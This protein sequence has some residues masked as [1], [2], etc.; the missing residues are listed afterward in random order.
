MTD[1]ARLT[2][3]FRGALIAE[4]ILALSAA[5]VAIATQPLLP[6]ELRAYLDGQADAPLN[7]RDLLEIA[8]GIIFLGLAASST[9]G[10]FLF[11][12]WARRLFVALTVTGFIPIVV[13]GPTVETGAATALAE[14]ATLL[15]GIILA[16]IYGSPVRDHFEKPPAARESSPEGA[17]RTL[18]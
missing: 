9:V 8:I 12:R 15:S 1:G 5:V 7:G 10:L 11:K 14:M 6:P 3:L 18:R 4:W 13:L 2:R 17:L 16:L